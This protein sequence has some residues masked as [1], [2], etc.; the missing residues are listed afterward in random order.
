MSSPA[1]GDLEA[2]LAKQRNECL[3]RELTAKRTRYVCLVG[4]FT[5][6][7]GVI[8]V[9]GLWMLALILIVVGLIFLLHYFDANGHLHEVQRRSTKRLVPDFS[10]LRRP[11][12]DT[13]T[14]ARPASR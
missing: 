12:G 7:A 10:V 11:E 5:M 4:L 9:L 1:T 14:T 6:L 8:G 3:Q 13:P 2:S